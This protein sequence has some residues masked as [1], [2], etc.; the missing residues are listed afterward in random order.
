MT[1]N[2]I[3][4]ENAGNQSIN[5]NSLHLVSDDTLKKK[6]ITSEIKCNSNRN[7]NELIGKYA[8]ITCVQHFLKPFP[9]TPFW[10][11][12]NSKKLQTTTEMWLLTL[13]QTTNF[14]LLKTE[15]VRRRQFI[16]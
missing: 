8:T 15:R 16:I 2:L 7:C 1:N 5:I 10:V 13:S 9:N 4:F 3:R 14:R 11:V 6:M 12:P